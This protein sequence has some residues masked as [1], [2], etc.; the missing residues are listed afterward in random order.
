MLEAGSSA[1]R[2]EAAA[3]TVA[4]P[5]AAAPSPV[6]ARTAVLTVLGADDGGE[7]NLTYTWAAKTAPSGASPAFSA[8]GT[9]ASKSSAVTFNK[10]GSYA[11]TVM[12]RDTT[13]LTVTSTVNVTVSQTVTAITVSPPRAVL[14]HSGM[15]AFTAACLD[16]FG[17]AIASPALTWS[18]DSGGVG[19]VNATTGLYTAGTINGVGKVR[20][21]RGAISNYADVSVVSAAPLAPASLKAAAGTRQV[22]LSW[23]ASTA[24]AYY[25]I[26]RGTA[27][28]GEGATA[29]NTSPVYGVSYTNAGLAAGS[30]YYYKVKAVNGVGSSAWSNE[31]NACTYCAAPASLTATRGSAKVQ[32]TWPAVSG[33]VSYNVKRSVTS[34]SGYTVVAGTSALTF[35]NTGLTNGTTYFYVVT[36]VNPA[37]EGPASVQASATPLAVPSAPANLTAAMSGGVVQLKW[38]ASAN[39]ISYSIYRG[40]MAGAESSTPLTSGITAT[41]YT[42]ANIANDGAVYYY[43]VKAVGAGGTS[44]ASSEAV[45][46]S[47][48][49][50][51]LN[52]LLTQDAGRFLYGASGHGGAAGSGTAFKFDPSTLSL[53]VLHSFSAV[54][55]N[56]YNT[57]GSFAV[58]GVILATDGALYGLTGSGGAAGLG[59]MYKIDTAG[60][61]SVVHTFA[62]YAVDGGSSLTELIQASDGRIYGTTPNSV[63][64]YDLTTK[65][66]QPLHIFAGGTNDGSNCVAS[67]VEGPDHQTVYGV[68]QNGGLYAKGVVFVID[69]PG[70]AFS[71]RSSISQNNPYPQ[72]AMTV[73]DDLSLYGVTSGLPGGRDGTFFSSGS[74]GYATALIHT[75]AQIP[76]TPSKPFGPLV[77]LSD[78]FFYGVSQYGGTSD[79]GSVF[80]IDTSGNVTTLHSFTGYVAGNAAG[81]DGSGPMKGV[82]LGLDG[83]LYGVTP[84]GGAGDSGGIYR[85]SPVTGTY[86]WLHSGH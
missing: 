68:T 85:I 16:Q 19:S 24:A 13:S 58:G 5:A 59:T 9:N 72:T 46:K 61:F 76:P 31:A 22:G 37:G 41:S 82:L 40:T 18:I 8:N 75:F 48:D 86:T 73:S 26:Y 51:Y 43:Y 28:G 50:A 52:C 14:A 32:L 62:S 33:A 83:C 74:S 25:N 79:K 81:S 11:F 78:H 4:T 70:A 53:T 30:H 71:I 23:T 49:V 10:A 42:D 57:D 20:A 54:D 56:G 38:S 80:K 39:A 12:I 34:G 2:V 7:A 44:P 21:A 84:A 63:F 1:V 60:N 29:I 27:A 65:I 77:E 3:P 6:T 35:T 67:L 36:A 47:V 66:F 69:E 45:A 17:A 15:Q 55:G 64:R